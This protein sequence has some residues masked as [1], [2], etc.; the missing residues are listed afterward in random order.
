MIRAKRPISWLRP[1]LRAFDEF[2]KGAQERGL[3]ALDL[4]AEGHKADIAK[5]MTGLGS[6]VF[7]I[8][9]RYRTDA[10]RAVYAVQLSEAIW[11]VHAFQKK[12]KQ[13]RRTPK[14]EIDLIR[15]RLGRLKD[16]LK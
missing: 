8:A 4:A 6:G 10:Y 1:A 2:P 13:G 14:S 16:L 12:S 15:H 3:Q 7:E 11:V 5:P 9:V